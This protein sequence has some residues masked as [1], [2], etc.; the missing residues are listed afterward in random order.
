MKRHAFHL[1]TSGIYSTH[2]QL[3]PKT[4]AAVDVGKKVRYQI[5]LRGDVKNGGT[6]KKLVMR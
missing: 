5:S 2:S 6:R 1:K 4:K 3:L